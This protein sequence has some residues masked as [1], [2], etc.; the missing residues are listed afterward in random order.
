MF[1]NKKIKTFEQPTVQPEVIPA[2]TETAEQP[3]EQV[4]E[5]ILEQSQERVAETPQPTSLPTTDELVVTKVAKDDIKLE[6]VE[7]ILSAGLDKMFLSMDPV[8]QQEFKAKGEE[9]ARKITVLLKTA[10]AT[11]GKIINLIV[12]WLRL[13]PRVN[14]HF[15]EQEAKIKAD[16]IMAIYK[17]NK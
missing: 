2:P 7:S 11:V 14:K 10:K 12:D 3:V 6:K 1:G 17:D 8:K 5:Q 16:Q 4:A 15:L 9:T 13:I